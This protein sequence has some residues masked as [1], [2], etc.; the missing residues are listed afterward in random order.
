MQFSIKNLN[1]FRCSFKIKK[2]EDALSLEHLLAPSS[3]RIINYDRVF[4]IYIFNIEIIELFNTQIVAITE[5]GSIYQTICNAYEKY[6]LHS[7]EL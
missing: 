6:T 1:L 4:I 7:I 3:L 2:K 5:F